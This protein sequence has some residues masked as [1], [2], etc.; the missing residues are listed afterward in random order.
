MGKIIVGA[1]RDCKICLS[2]I[3]WRMASTESGS[4]HQWF[5]TG[6]DFFSAQLAAIEAARSS[7][8]FEVYIFQAGPLGGRF[9]DALARAAGRG[10]RVRALVDAAGSL[11]LPGDFWEPLRQAGGEARL[12]NPVALKRFWIRNHRKLLVCDGAVAFVG[13]FNTA[14]EY[15]G[16]G[17]TRGWRDLGLSITGRVA[18]ILEE[19]F[20]EMF[21]SADFLHKRFLRLRRTT[22]RKSVTGPGAK[23]LFSGPG[24]GP[25]PFAR[26]LREDLAKAREVKIVMAYFLPSWQLRRQLLRVVQRGGRVR[27]ML[28]AKSDVLLS[29]LAGRSLYRRLLNGG[30][31]I[32][33]YQPQ[34]LH[35][36]LLLV[37][38]AVYSGSSN[39]D[40]RSLRINYEL[41]IRFENP[42]M[43]KT[44]GQIFDEMLP[45]CQRIELAAWHRGRSLWRRVKQRLAYWL[46]MRLDPWVA[47]WQWR[48]L[49]K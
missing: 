25:N 40:P 19:S 37:D 18:K 5:C 29:Q 20:E 23:L 47:R 27:L 7:V 21:A 16:D 13:G 17:I 8:C 38:G 34:I 32:Y 12:F 10:V 39:L 48:A 35:A 31:E 1:G 36:K 49:P 46:L 41:M 6:D 9:R 44:A 42:E 24:R 4:T 14:A 45:H 15:E 43:T 33:E 11:T 2:R 30:V 22:A 3:T 26:T 28:A